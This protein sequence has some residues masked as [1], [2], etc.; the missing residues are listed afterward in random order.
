MPYVVGTDEAGYGPNLGP[1]VIS[2]SVWE[3]PDGL[4]ADDLYRVLEG[5]IA[6]HPGA[7]QPGGSGPIAIADSK[8]L[9]APSRGIALLERG[10][11]GALGVLGQAP[12]SWRAT[13][14]A[15][16]PRS[17][18]A[19]DS[20]PWFAQYDSPIPLENSPAQVEQAAQTLRAGLASAGVRLVRLEGHA[21]FEAQFNQLVQAHASKGTVLSQATLA[22]IDGLTADL[23]SGPIL[24][25]CDKHG[26]R[27]SYRWLLEQRFPDALIEVYGE[28]RQ[29]SVYR[30]GPAE[31]RLEI[32]F[33]AKAERCLPAALASMASKYLRELA[34]RALN[35]FWCARV[36]GLAPT[37]GYPADAKRF[38]RAIA[39][40]QAELGIPDSLLW[41]IK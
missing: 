27:N 15:L 34:M 24:I 40:A 36:P 17:A 9:Y 26:A 3:V 32:R 2:A 21:V 5:V 18:S 14:R 25:L 30:F 1:L 12:R 37:A 39:A 11:L 23:R 41:R 7:G 33:R 35:A 10:V 20:L 19:L 4:R 22:L 28:S 6:A 31:R 38:K 16:A 13:W 8:S 29:E